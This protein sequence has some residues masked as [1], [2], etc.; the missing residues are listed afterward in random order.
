MKR[1]WEVVRLI[2]EHIE[3][4]DLYDYLRSESWKNEKYVSVGEDEL[5]GHIEILE[6]AGLIRGASIQRS[7]SGRI[8]HC[9]VFGAHVTM[10]GHDLLDALRDATVWNSIKEKA[11]KVGSSLSWEFIKAALPCVMQELVR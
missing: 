3:S 11:R 10:A 6:E 8:A 4:E 1:R 5:L 9:S 7:A 2:L